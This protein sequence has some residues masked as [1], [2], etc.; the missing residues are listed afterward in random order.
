MLGQKSGTAMG[1]AFVAITN[2]GPH[3][4]ETTADLCTRKIVDISEAAA[5]HIRQ[6]AE[7][8]RDRLQMVLTFYM[9]AT[10]ANER[11]RIAMIFDNTHPE[12]AAIIR[13]KGV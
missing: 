7:A 10:A 6:Q 2:G 3:S 12:I 4:P 5:P 8:F 9:K 1:N 13:N 11:E